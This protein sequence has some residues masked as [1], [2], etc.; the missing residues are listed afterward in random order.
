ME[1]KYTVKNQHAMFTKRNCRKNTH[2][3]TKYSYSLYHCYNSSL[4][5]VKTLP[6]WKF[7]TSAKSSL[8]VK[9]K[10]G[11]TGNST[12][13]LKMTEINI[14]WENIIFFSFSSQN[15][16]EEHAIPVW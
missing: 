10:V 8:S 3:I 12:T 4:I 1:T 2:V 16:R 7:M 15:N 11:K 13:Y 14:R 5:S 9:D 6:I